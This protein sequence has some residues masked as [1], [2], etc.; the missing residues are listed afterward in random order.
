MTDGLRRE[1]V[2][3]Q[4]EPP[5]HLYKEMLLKAVVMADESRSLMGLPTVHTYNGYGSR[6]CKDKEYARTEARWRVVCW[7]GWGEEGG[8][9]S[10]SV[11]LQT[12]MPL[13][14]CSVPRVKSRTSLQ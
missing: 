11:V 8:T 4:C 14:V 5:C 9:A 7:S 3:G 1:G 13:L 10:S 2:N 6:V 12:D